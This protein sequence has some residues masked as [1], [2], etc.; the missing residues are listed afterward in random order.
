MKPGAKLIEPRDAVDVNS[1]A[2][3]GRINAERSEYGD[4]CTYLVRLLFGV[5][6]MRRHCRG[7]KE[8]CFSMARIR[9]S[10]IRGKWEIKRAG[11]VSLEVEIY[12]L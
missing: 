5:H 1:F 2:N 9:R 4:S 11:A 7:R 3:L 12:Y 10:K 8:M 6:M